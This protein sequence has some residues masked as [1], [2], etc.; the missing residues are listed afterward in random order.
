[1]SEHPGLSRFLCYQSTVCAIDSAA[2]FICGKN[3]MACSI[4]RRPVGACAEIEATTLPSPSRTG[5]S[6]R[7]DA[8]DVL[9]IVDSKALFAHLFELKT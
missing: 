1:M 4:L 9:L 8:G 6:K 7:D 5:T 3:S 2:C